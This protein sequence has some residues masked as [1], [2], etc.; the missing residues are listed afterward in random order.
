MIDKPRRV[1]APPRTVRS[2]RRVSERE[3]LG[4]PWLAIALGPDADRGERRGHARGIVAIGDVAT[5][6]IA[7]GGMARGLVAF[8][9]LAIGAVSFGGLAIGALAFGGGAV[10]GFAVGGAAIGI[11]AIGGFAIGH[12]A[13]GGAAFG[14]YPLSPLERSPEAIEFFRQL[15]Q[16]WQER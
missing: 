5:G 12:F 8:G 7:I 2:I 1:D 4:L 6:L 3:F 15:G 9:G 16:T 14:T 11:V 10:G 13:A